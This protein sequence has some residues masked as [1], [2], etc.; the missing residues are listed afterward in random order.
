VACVA[1]KIPEFFGKGVIGGAPGGVDPNHGGP[2]D[3]PVVRNFM[4]PQ[5]SVTGHLQLGRFS[6]QAPTWTMRGLSMAAPPT[7]LRTQRREGR[8]LRLLRRIGADDENDACVVEIRGRL[9]TGDDDS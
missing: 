3:A 8:R 4:P 5:S 9:R 6:A 1:A 7:Y 2:L